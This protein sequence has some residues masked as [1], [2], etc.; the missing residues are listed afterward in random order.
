MVCLHPLILGS[1]CLFNHVSLSTVDF[2]HPDLV[3]ELTDIKDCGFWSTE[4][5]YEKALP[6][7]NAPVVL[8]QVADR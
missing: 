4:K 2:G 5:C 6:S 8:V 1:K 3:G 7:E